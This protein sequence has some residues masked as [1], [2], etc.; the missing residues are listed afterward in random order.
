[1]VATEDPNGRTL[2]FSK[3]DTDSSTYAAWFTN[4]PTYTSAS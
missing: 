3:S 2:A 1:M 4:V